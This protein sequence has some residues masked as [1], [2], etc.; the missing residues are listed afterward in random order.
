MS[1]DVVVVFKF[2]IDGGPDSEAATKAVESLT[3]DLTNAGID[4]DSWHIEEVLGE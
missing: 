2:D 4:C 1:V 3:M